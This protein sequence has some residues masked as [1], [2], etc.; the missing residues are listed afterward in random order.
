MLSRLLLHI[1]SVQPAFRVE[2]VIFAHHCNRILMKYL[3]AVFPT[4]V[5]CVVF[6]FSCDKC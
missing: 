3:G 4:D 2:I 5:R 1:R 6:L